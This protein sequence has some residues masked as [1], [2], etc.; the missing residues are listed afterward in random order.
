DA[1]QV[2]LSGVFSDADGD[3]LTVTARSSAAAV[4][5]VSVASGYGSLTVSAKAEGTATVTVTADDGNGG[6]VSDSFTVAVE[7]ANQAPAV[8]PEPA[9]GELAAPGNLECALRT[10]GSERVQCTWDSATGATRGY[11]VEY[12]MTLN[13]RGFTTTVARQKTTPS[14]EYSIGANRY[15]ANAKIR[16]AA[17]GPD[18]TGPFTEWATVSK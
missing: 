4:A 3:S 15:M 18:G 11:A 13:L 12:E 6:T 7:A 5:T 9:G 17:I 14:A 16:V 1:R 2:S 8:V 10:Q